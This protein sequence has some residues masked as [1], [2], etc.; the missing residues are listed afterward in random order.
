MAISLLAMGLV[1]Q[2]LGI[3]TDSSLIALCGLPV[4]II[5][6]SFFTGRP[7][8]AILLLTFGLIPVPAFVAHATSPG[9]ESMLGAGAVSGL[10][11]LRVPIEVTGPLLLSGEAR[12]ELLAV[13]GGIVTA[14]LLA[15]VG[16]YLAIRAKRGMAQALVQAILWA[17]LAIVIQPLLVLLCVSTLPLGVPELGRFV[18]THGLVLFI[19]SIVLWQHL[20]DHSHIHTTTCDI[21]RGH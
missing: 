1:A 14:V 7:D 15:E 17:L 3:A 20:R 9:L 18:L 4:A 5:G 6:I 11:L 21:R 10:N 2:I 13:D 12:F 19:G 8:A 16:W